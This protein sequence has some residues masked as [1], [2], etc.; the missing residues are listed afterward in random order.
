MCVL[1][2]FSVGYS[3]Y[4]WQPSQEEYFLRLVIRS[5]SYS[6]VFLEHCWNIF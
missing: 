2:D 1:E 5:I 3:A 4:W 6:S